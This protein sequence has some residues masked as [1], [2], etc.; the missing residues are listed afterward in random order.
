MQ[1]WT[2]TTRTERWRLKQRTSPVSPERRDVWK[3]TEGGTDLAIVTV[4]QMCNSYYIEV[5]TG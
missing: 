4:P 2:E 5:F 1:R 3:K